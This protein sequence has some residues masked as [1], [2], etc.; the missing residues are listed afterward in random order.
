MAWN[1]TFDLLERLKKDEDFAKKWQAFFEDVRQHYKDD[2]AVTYSDRG[3]EFERSP[4]PYLPY[5]GLIFDGLGAKRGSVGEA[6]LHLICDLARKH[7]GETNVRFEDEAQSEMLD[8]LY[9]NMHHQ[10]SSKQSS[11]Y[12]YGD[13]LRSLDNDDD[14]E[15]Y[16]NETF[17][18]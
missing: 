17:Y 2:P 1:V 16:K 4:I 8:D 9:E 3:A 6:K 13:W 18:E 14:H 15:A 10:Q 12:T 5:D 7:F 11:Q